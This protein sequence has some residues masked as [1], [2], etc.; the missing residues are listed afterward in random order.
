MPTIWKKLEVIFLSLH[1]ISLLPWALLLATVITVCST[2][3][4]LQI[5][6]EFK[7]SILTCTWTLQISSGSIFQQSSLH[8][9]L[10]NLKGF[11]FSAM[12]F[13]TILGIFQQSSS[14]L[15]LTFSNLNGSIL[16]QSALHFNFSSLLKFWISILSNLICTWT[17]FQIF[18][19]FFEQQNNQP[20]PIAPY[21][22]AKIL[23][24][25]VIIFFF[26]SIWHKIGKDIA[27]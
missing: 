15:H 25:D 1:K 7:F 24:D 14:L 22:A 23:H 19:S 20:W 26:L 8:L 4:T 2:N 18:W 13:S 17:S 27:L 12:K 6:W 9:N 5:S 10:S 3:W 21:I 16:Q 11:K